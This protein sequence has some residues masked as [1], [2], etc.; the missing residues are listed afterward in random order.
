MANG[1]RSRQADVS[2]PRLRTPVYLPRLI[3]KRT[4]SIAPKAVRTLKGN[5]Q[6]GGISSTFRFEERFIMLR[7]CVEPC[8]DRLRLLRY[9][10]HLVIVSHESANGVE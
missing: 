1:H 5:Q 4:R 9:M 6:R 8:E 3:T 10:G 7:P 2:Q